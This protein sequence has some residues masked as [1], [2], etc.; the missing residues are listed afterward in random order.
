[1]NEHLRQTRANLRALEEVCREGWVR[2]ALLVVV[3][4]A[5]GVMAGFRVNVTRS[6]PLGLYRVVGNASAV[7]R[8]SVVIVCLPPE[9]ARFALQREILG[10]GHCEGGSYGLGKM[11]LATGGDVVELR[12]DGLTLNGHP[13]PNSRTLKWDSHGRPM[14]HYSWGMHVLRPGEVWLFSPYHPAA[15][16]S[17]YFGP[18][19]TSRIRSVVRP[20]WAGR[21]DDQV[22]L[23][24]KAEF[25]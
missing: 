20:V 6:Y 10:P 17:R 3:F 22:Q 2:A 12:R 23:G 25:R 7:E 21:P 24:G 15:F 16:D 4:L 11:V 5:A 19:S 14:P 9:W 13:V 1:M 8:G 18:V